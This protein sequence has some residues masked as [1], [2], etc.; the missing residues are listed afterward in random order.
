[1]SRF[2]LKGARVVDPAS[3]TDEVTDVTIR[4]G[5]IEAVGDAATGKDSEAIDCDGAVLAPGF[6]DMHAHLREPGREDEETVVSGSAAAAAGGY[7]ALCA[8][9]NTDPVAD[10]AAIV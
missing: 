9:P 1:M 10:S 5:V 8:M 6:V 2:L 4:E 7:T 3:G